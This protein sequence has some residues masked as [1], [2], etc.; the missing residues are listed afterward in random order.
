[1]IALHV[2]MDT[3]VIIGRKRTEGE[4]CTPP[5]VMFGGLDLRLNG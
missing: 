1:M 5:G 2:N 4:F 3:F